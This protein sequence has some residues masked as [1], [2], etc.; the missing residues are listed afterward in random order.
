MIQFDEHIV[1]M[2]WFNHQLVIVICPDDSFAIFPAWVASSKWVQVLTPPN[3][4]QK[5]HRP[6]NPLNEATKT[7]KNHQTNLD[8]FCWTLEWMDG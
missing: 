1:Q 2:G 3:P 6:T 4:K 8:K 5:P 7:T